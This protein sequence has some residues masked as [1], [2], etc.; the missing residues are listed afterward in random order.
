VKEIFIPEIRDCSET[1]SEPNAKISVNI[2]SLNYASEVE[3]RKTND[4]Y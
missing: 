4:I 1:R 3:V 2:T